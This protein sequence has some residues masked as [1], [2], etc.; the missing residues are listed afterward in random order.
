MVD[1]RTNAER[2]W[3]GFVPG[4][5]GGGMEAVAGDG[6]NPDFD[7]LPDSG[8]VGSAGRQA[9]ADAVPAPGVRS[10]ASAKRATELGLT[11]YNILKASGRP[12]QRRIAIAALATVA[13][14]GRT[15]GGSQRVSN[16]KIATLAARA[17]ATPASATLP[18]GDVTPDVGAAQR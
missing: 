8:A 16:K 2:E 4:R 3:V 1:I 12:R 5:T 11:A 9:A 10:I 15:T 13:Y 6:V 18:A 7:A 17:S 14:R